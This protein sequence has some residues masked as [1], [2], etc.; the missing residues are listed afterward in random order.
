MKDWYVG[1]V[2]SQ[3]LWK[4]GLKYVKL[5]LW[6]R[7]LTN[8]IPKTETKIPVE[9][10][11][12]SI[13]DFER[14]PLLKDEAAKR[15]N[16]GDLGFIAVW[17]GMVVGYLWA[18]FK[19]KVYLG[20]IEREVSF[21]TGGVYLYDGFVLPNFRRKGLF[22]KLL[23]EALQYFKSRNV[24]KANAGTLTNNKAP[25]KAFKA[26][27]FSTVRLVKFVKIFLFKKFEELELKSHGKI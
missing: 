2:F 9:I 26:L 15:L 8:E 22:K 1:R 18:S 12:A 25:Q 17:N 6:E 3:C 19:R 21:K 4:I 27:G 5:L 23:E 20:E 14:S 13:R 10:R 11:L 16:E 7:H 24:K